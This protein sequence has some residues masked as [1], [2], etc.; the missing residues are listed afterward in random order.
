MSRSNIIGLSV[1]FLTVVLATVGSVDT[2]QAQSFDHEEYPQLDFSFNSLE[3]DLGIQPQ[4]L[5]IDGAAKYE[6]EANIAGADTLILYASHIDISAVSVNSESVDYSLNNDSLYIPV[7]DSAE[8]G[9]QFDI[10]IRYSGRP[11]FGLL[12]NAGGTVWTSQLP[13]AQRHWV[14]IVDNPHVELKTTFNIALPAGL[15]LWATGQKTSEEAVSVDVMRYQFKSENKVPASSLAFA[16]GKFD[17]QSTSYGIKKI[18]L[19]VEQTLADT[20]DS[21]QIL[22]KAY[23]Y[24][25]AV[26]DQ[27]QFEYPYSRLNIVILEDH[28]WETKSWGASTVFLYE[29]RG[30]WKTQ[31][32]R[33]IIAQWFGIYQRESRWGQADAL[34]LYQIL[35]SNEISEVSGK[36]VVNDVPDNTPATIYDNFGPRRW[37][38]WQ[39]LI[40]DWQNRSLRAQISGLATNILD[41]LLSVITWSDYADFW[42]RMTGQPLF[43]MPVFSTQEDPVSKQPSDS[44]A[45]KVNYSLNEAE[46]EL[47][48]RFE[49]THNSYAELTTLQA[50]EV[51]P[52]ETDTAEVTFTGAQD[53]VVLQVDPTI[54]NLK[55]EAPNNPELVLDEYKPA[56]F[57]INEFQQGETVE[58]RTETARKL[59]YHSENP[60]LQL[61]IRDFMDKELEPRVKAALL[62][63]LGDITNGATG[64][65]QLFIDALQSDFSEI[66]DAGLMALQNYKGNASIISR[67]KLVGQNADDIAL[68]KKATQVL[69]AI[70][71]QEEYAGFVETVTQQDSL[72]KRSVFAVQELANMGAVDEA[73]TRAKLFTGDQ[74]NYQIR[75]RALEIL[76]QHDHSSSD[77]LSRAEELFDDADPRIR[78]LVVQGLERNLNEEI[79]E[80]LGVRIQDEYDARVYHK[81]Q[82]VISDK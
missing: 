33:G 72:G 68:F 74:Y 23:D 15:K 22:Q 52:N 59:G 46:G 5:R 82:Q 60:D 69:T 81:I 54:Q 29:N 27:L 35:L 12:K 30:D 45:Y 17:Q 47:K 31:L 28:S 77:W 8:K 10:N 20:I 40:A 79:T 48:L 9:Q 36:L 76:I 66:R 49:A 21:Q 18:N 1:L 41:T 42:Y 53:S 57:L 64:T 55:V 62:S 38:Q 4:N 25:G 65:E 78:F 75:S 11:Q 63:S 37:N 51:Y 43:E 7:V 56:L 26:E 6:V 67:V 80:F 70:A 44:V 24:L 39:A 32:L 73:V 61:A 34:T 13:E 16:I 14:P 71:S 58:K 3:L 19:A 50:Y 2:L